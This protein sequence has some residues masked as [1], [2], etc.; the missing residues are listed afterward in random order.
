MYCIWVL[1]VPVVVSMIYVNAAVCNA[2]C[3]AILMQEVKW[4]LR[5]VHGAFISGKRISGLL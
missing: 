3:T 2:D 1:C 5:A 4:R